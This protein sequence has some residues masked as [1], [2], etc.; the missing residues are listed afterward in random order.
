MENFQ[1]ERRDSIRKEIDT[2]KE[3]LQLGKMKEITDKETK[4][5]KFP[6]KWKWAMNKST[7]SAGI[8]KVLVFFLNIKG[9]IEPPKLIPLFSGNI[10]IWKNKAYDFDPRATWTLKVGRKMIKAVIV[11]EIDRRP[12]S[13]L[14]WDEVKKR[15]DSTDSDE[16]LIK[17]VTKVVIE[18]TKAKINRTAIFFIVLAIIAA[19]IAIVVL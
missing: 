10:I 6:F 11:K 15:E 8:D 14:D 16:I 5:W 18:K 13:N 9:E 19:I 3:E 7:G 12:V 17:M 2:L 4:E 1:S